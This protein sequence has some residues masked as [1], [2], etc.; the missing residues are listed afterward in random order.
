M[1]KYFLDVVIEEACLSFPVNAN[2]RT[3]D[4][5]Q[6]NVSDFSARVYGPGL[7]KSWRERVKKP[8]G[9]TVDEAARMAEALGRPLS[10]MIAEAARRMRMAQKDV[11][12]QQERTGTLG[13]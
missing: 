11:T 10:E 9:L 5:F 3:S 12:V 2:R 1:S 6:F 8:Y 13:A 4:T 7:Q